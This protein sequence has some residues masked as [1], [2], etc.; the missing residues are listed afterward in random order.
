MNHDVNSPTKSD[1]FRAARFFFLLSF[2]A[3]NALAQ[4]P[5][6]GF[7]LVGHIEDLT[8][9]KPDQPL[10]SG[11]IVINGTK[12]I[13]PANLLIKFPGQYLTVHDVHLGRKPIVAR[14]PPPAAVTR[15]AVQSKT[16][17]ALKDPP[18]PVGQP[19]FI[20]PFEATVVGNI[21]PNDG[22]ATA[23]QYVAGWVSIAQLSLAAGSG[24]IVNIDSAT[25]AIFV[26]GRPKG[27]TALAGEKLAVV[28]INDPTGMYGKP[29]AQKGAGDVMDERFAVDPGNAPVTAQTGFPMCLPES[30]SDAN[31]PLANRPTAAGI[32]AS[33]FTCGAFAGLTFAPADPGCNPNFKA[34]L[35]VGDYITYAG[36]LAE[37]QTSKQL[38]IAAHAVQA[39]IGIY[40]SPGIDPAYVLIEDAIF[41]AL[42][43]RFP[44]PF[45]NQEQTGRLKIV[46]FTTDPSRIVDVIALDRDASAETERTPAL[47]NLTPSRVAQ[48]GRIRTEPFLKANSLPV[49]RDIRIRIANSTSVKTAGGNES[50]S[51]LDSGQ[52]SAPIGEYIMPENTRWGIPPFPISA[53]FENFCFLSKG[54]G[55]LDTLGRDRP[56]D[57]SRL[58]IGP[59]VP[60]P[61]SGHPLPQTKADNVTPACR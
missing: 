40:T 14:P 18:A 6:V 49:P 37:E 48:I 9:D 25:G 31:C 32:N 45:E 24:Y 59:L 41:G 57:L 4:V 17:L 15:A 28:R 5:T 36:T 56:S 1:L 12:V 10:S 46:G 55:Q 34:P 60:F 33:R 51:G 42:G 58:T 54:G 26:A 47:L 20:A 29:N 13:L 53:P 43:Q 35:Q 50:G 8:L 61:K 39:A 7:T 16:G 52:Y 44:T 19:R 30:A 11:T 22:S 27:S 21:M 3:T 38:F 23:N 2:C